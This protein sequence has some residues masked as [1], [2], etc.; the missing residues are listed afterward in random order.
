MPLSLK[1]SELPNPV[2]L[3][4][5]ENMEYIKRKEKEAAEKAAKK[6]GRTSGVRSLKRLGYE[7]HD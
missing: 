3:T 6:T 1:P 5:P 4:A 2:L 7:G